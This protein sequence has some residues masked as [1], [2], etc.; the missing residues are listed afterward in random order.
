MPMCTAALLSFPGAGPPPQCAP[1]CGQKDRHLISPGLPTQ[2]LFQQQLL[3]IFAKQENKGRSLP[4]PRAC[5]ASRSYPL[6]SCSS[7]ILERTKQNDVKI[8]HTLHFN[9]WFSV[10]IP[11]SLCDPRHTEKQFKFSYG[12]KISI[13]IHCTGKQPQPR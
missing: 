9:P 13:Q 4:W 10:C 5:L 2:H 1:R 7:C 11:W 12:G 3:E 8:L 6:V